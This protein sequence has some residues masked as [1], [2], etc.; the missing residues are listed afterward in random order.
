LFNDVPDRWARKGRGGIFAIAIMPCIVGSPSR[1]VPVFNEFEVVFGHLG[2][3]GRSNTQSLNIV[4][5]Q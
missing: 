4:F 3:K 2:S 5:F 1:V